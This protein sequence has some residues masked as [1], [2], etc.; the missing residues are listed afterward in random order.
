M[1]C[2]TLDNSHLTGND[3]SVFQMQTVSS[4]RAVIRMM[5]IP[6]HFAMEHHDPHTQGLWMNALAI[7]ESIME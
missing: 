7:A 5:D 6:D 4:T 2:K 3:M 1:A